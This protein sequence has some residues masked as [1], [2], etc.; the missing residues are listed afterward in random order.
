[1]TPPKDQDED[2]FESAGRRPRANDTSEIAADDLL[3][4]G[5][6]DVP[7][8]PA[9]LAEL[10]P[11]LLEDE[12]DETDADRTAIGS[13]YSRMQ[14]HEAEPTAHDMPA[15]DLPST[16]EEDDDEHDKTII[17]SLQGR[18]RQHS[19][20][21]EEEP[22]EIAIDDIELEDADDDAEATEIGRL[23]S[24]LESELTE[25][26]KP[27]P[28]PETAQQS[29][30]REP[31]PPRRIDPAAEPKVV[32]ALDPPDAKELE[33]QPRTDKVGQPRPSLVAEEKIE[34]LLGRL[35]ETPLAG[36]RARIFKQIA[37]LFRD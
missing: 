32:V 33:T 34:A 14:Q 18:M 6:D 30:L 27:F 21:K 13:L 20:A 29:S 4:V 15:R 7:P 35:E 36:E 24:F 26:R 17:G 3:E 25:K 9:S 8:P 31:P 23:P 28:Q 12:G 37:V 5:A 11:A 22:E 16:Y 1:M 2:M 19:V 10:D